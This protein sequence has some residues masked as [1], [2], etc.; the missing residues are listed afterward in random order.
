MLLFYKSLILCRRSILYNQTVRTP[1][2]IYYDKIQQLKSEVTPH[3]ATYSKMIKS[4]YE[5]D[6]DYTLAEAGVLRAKI[7]HIAEK[8]DEYSKAMLTLERGPN[9]TRQYD[10]K[11]FIRLACVKFIKDQMLCLEALPLESDINERQRKR[12]QETEQRIERERRL[13]ME[14]WER[15]EGNRSDVSEYT[16]TDSRNFASGVSL[17]FFYA[18][19]ILL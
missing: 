17:H 15:N 7:G 5:G 11:K 10:L 9:K 13:A 16:Q 2:T 6:S 8:L 18:F 14:Q 12:K 4:L 1:I 19:S 3:L